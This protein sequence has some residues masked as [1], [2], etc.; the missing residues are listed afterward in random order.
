MKMG[1]EDEAKFRGL[2]AV[3]DEEKHPTDA[4]KKKVGNTSRVEE[5]VKQLMQLGHRTWRE[6]RHH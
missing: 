4:L 3:V 2:V 1:R 6:S 5:L